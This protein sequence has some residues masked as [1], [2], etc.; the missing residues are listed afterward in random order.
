MFPRTQSCINVYYN[1]NNKTRENIKAIF[2]GDQQK[3]VID[4]T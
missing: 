1:D 2:N 4:H 3:L